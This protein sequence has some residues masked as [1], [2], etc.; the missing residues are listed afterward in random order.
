MGALGLAQAVTFLVVPRLSPYPVLAWPLALVG[1]CL[2]MA[3]VLQARRV[4]VPWI[5]A[6]AASAPVLVIA[7]LGWLGPTL[8]EILSTR[9]LA[10]TIAGDVR[11]SEP[12]LASP[13]LARGVAYYS[14]QPVTVLSNRTRPF[15][16]QH[17]L[18]VVVGAEGLGRYLKEERTALCALTAHDWSRLGPK[19]PRESWTVQGRCGDKVLARLSAATGDATESPL[20]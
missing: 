18:P 17:P 20:P 5:I 1:A 6:S 3:L 14:R 16:T 11:P 13:T 8:D 2:V 10:R 7:C 19:L 12:V 15:Y 9:S 4:S